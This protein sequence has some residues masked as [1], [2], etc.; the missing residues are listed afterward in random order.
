MNIEEL[1]EPVKKDIE[2][3]SLEVLEKIASRIVVIGG[4]GVRAHLGESHHRYTLDVDGVTDEGTLG[5]LRE[6]FFSMGFDEKPVEWGIKFFKKY[7]PRV[8]IPAGFEALVNEVE[9]RMEISPP[10]IQEHDTQHYFEFSLTDFDILEI[11]YHNKDKSVKVRVPPIEHMTA[12]KLGLP[13]DYKHNHDAAMLLRKSDIDKVVQAIKSNDDWANLVM[14]RMPKLKR[15]IAQS[16]RIENT[17]A[18]AA[19]LDIGQHIK[20]LEQIEQQIN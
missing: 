8:D 1:S 3:Q 5:E 14:R 13:V 6:L 18:I 17:L 11:P 9:L 15:R 2:D 20:T 7:V 12:V 10:R 16:G 4:W 19:G